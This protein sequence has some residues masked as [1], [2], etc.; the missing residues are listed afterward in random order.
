MET[1]FWVTLAAAWLH[2]LSFTLAKQLWQHSS[3]PVQIMTYGQVSCALLALPAAGWIGVA[4]LLQAPGAILLLSVAIV[5]A[6]FTFTQAMR[7]GDASFVVPMMGF[8]LLIVAV[9]SAFWLGEI[10]KPLVYVGAAGA[11]ASLFLL[12]D[13]RPPKS[14]S[15]VFWVLVT[16]TLF[17]FI[18]V[19]I[20]RLIHQGLSPMAIA[21]Y[22]MVGPSLLLLPLL[23]HRL[24]GRWGLSR[25]F[26]RDLAGYSLTQVA[27]LVLLMLAFGLAGKATIINILQTSR[28]LWVLVVVYGL[29]KLGLNGME[30][31]SARQYAWRVS[32]A[33]LMMCSLAVVILSGR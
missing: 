8:K 15:S 13:G 6:Q 22:V 32:G 21:F 4:P 5:A 24:R 11:F 18:D 7:A 26:G 10:Y 17:G 16:C 28:G 20:V 14:L 9:L 3:D 23:L 12:T 27:G 1:Y 30:R 33:S 19:L 29:G 25:A 31:L 2:A